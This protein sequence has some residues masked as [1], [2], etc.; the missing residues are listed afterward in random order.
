MKKLVD[1]Y[2][3]DMIDIEYYNN[4]YNKLKKQ[5]EA[6]ESKMC[7]Q[8]TSIEKITKTKKMLNNDFITLYSS[9]SDNE[10]RNIWGQV[11]NYLI[12]DIKNKDEFEIELIID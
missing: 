10:K 8:T 12:I 4:E 7:A 1:L 3:N 5:L 11:F 9:L 6:E 2:L